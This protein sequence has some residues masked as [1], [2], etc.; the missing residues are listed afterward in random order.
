MKR[1]LGTIT[2]AALAALLVAA[3]AARAD[4]SNDSIP[5]LHSPT[6]ATLL[7]TVFTVVPAVAGIVITNGEGRSNGPDQGAGGPLLFTGAYLFGP[8]V[9]HFY[10]GRSGRAFV[11]IGVRAAALAAATGAVAASW[12][13]GSDTSGAET[14]GLVALGVGVVS[15]VYDVATAGKSAK[16]KND[17]L[18]AQRLTEPKVSASLGSVAGAP[19]VRIGVKF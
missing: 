12:D 2:A 15:A 1:L 4:D 13:N 18:R 16:I 9:G 10:A 17:E 8:A 3:P 19:G 6:T 11:G 14:V 7:S 5:G